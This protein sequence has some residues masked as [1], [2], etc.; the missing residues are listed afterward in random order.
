[1]NIDGTDCVRDKHNECKSIPL[2]L[3]TPIYKFVNGLLK[4]NLNTT[5]QQRFPDEIGYNMNV[6]NTNGWGSAV[7]VEYLRNQHKTFLQKI[8]KYLKN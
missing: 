3:H 5:M 1:M 8:N 4:T 6:N 2:K 7:T